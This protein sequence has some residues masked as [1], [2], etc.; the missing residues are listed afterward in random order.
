MEK[1]RTS[2]EF[3]TEFL[4]CIWHLQGHN[5]H[6]EYPGKSLDVL[7]LALA[8]YTPFSF[9]NWPDKWSWERIFAR[10]EAGLRNPE[11]CYL[12]FF[13]WDGIK[14]APGCF[15]HISL[16]ERQTHRQKE[17]R[18]KL[19]KSKIA[20]VPGQIVSLCGLVHKATHWITCFW[21][22]TSILLWKMKK[23]RWGKVGQISGFLFKFATN[24]Y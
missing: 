24:S 8:V 3:S 2:V 14:A 15:Y 20:A 10:L 7:P 16:L 23:R 17:G 11:P 9:V 5:M 4:F 18:T 6:R 13:K 1:I 22:K 12:I 21:L 19:R